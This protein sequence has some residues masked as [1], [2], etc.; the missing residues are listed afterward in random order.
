MKFLILLL[1]III[2]VFL[3]I[4]TQI[5]GVVF[6]VSNL[7]CLRWKKK[8]RLKNTGVFLVLYLFT[9]FAI[10]PVVAPLFGR[11]KI[12]HTKLIQ[13]TNYF[14]VL[15]NRNYVVP[16]VNSLLSNTE[17]LLKNTEISIH[18]LDANFPFIN[19]FPLLPH[20]SHNDGKKLDLSLIYENK[21]GIISSK[22]KS[23]SGYGVYENPRKNEFNQIDK[24][25]KKGHFQ[26]DLAKYLKIRKINKDLIF[27]NK[28]TKKLINSILKNKSIE[29]IFIEPHLKSRFHL[30]HSKIRYH[31]CWA[32][33]HDDHIHIQVK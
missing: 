19:Q 25:L 2:F 21:N 26:Y 7:L 13:P 5:G 15:L 28:G 16:E 9:T 24:C 6:I 18:Y 12:K 32:V 27:S 3:T 14:T 30:N 8:F 10:I 4:I 22:Q 11:E 23:I 33:R 17:R 1:K 20:L 31:G 29:K